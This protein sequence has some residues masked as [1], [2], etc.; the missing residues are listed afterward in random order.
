MYLNE[1]L[2]LRGV[3]ANALTVPEAKLLGINTGKS[4]W[5]ADHAH[6]EVPDELATLAKKSPGIPA[7]KAKAKAMMESGYT[8]R[9]TVDPF[10]IHESL[11]R[12]SLLASMTED[13]LLLHAYVNSTPEVRQHVQAAVDAL[14]AAYQAIG[15]RRD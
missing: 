3:N 9:G 4:G 10:A 13:F 7:L 8:Y 1:Y 6:V 12:C 11:D 2:K 15:N 14:G 5:V